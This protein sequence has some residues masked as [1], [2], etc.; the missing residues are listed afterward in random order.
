MNV[1]RTAQDNNLVEQQKH[2]AQALQQQNQMF[3]QLMDGLL[4]SMDMQRAALESQIQNTQK[5]L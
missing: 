1:A 2:I 5:S 4:Q 3:A